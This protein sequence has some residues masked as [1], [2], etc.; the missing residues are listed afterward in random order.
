MQRQLFRPE[1]NQKSYLLECSIRGIVTNEETCLQPYP[2]T[3]P[4]T[5]SVLSAATNVKHMDFNCNGRL[6]HYT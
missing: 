2:I 1:N 5:S 3:V 4:K 6:L